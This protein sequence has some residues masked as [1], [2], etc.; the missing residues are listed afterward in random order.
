VSSS[1]LD[2]IKRVYAAFETYDF[3]VIE[4][5]FDP[6]VEIWQS[7]LLPWGGRF[8]GHQGA[9]A[10][11]SGLLSHVKTAVT[12]DQLIDAG[13]HVIEVGRTAGT[14]IATGASF[15]VPEIH[16]WRLREGK[17]I[18]MHAYIETPAVLVALSEP[19]PA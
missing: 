19:T 7:E 16:V 3:G 10:F 5:V 4:E 8:T 18:S 12:V 15:D 9:V 2:V 6:E 14:A 17:V 13:D 11:F 1:D